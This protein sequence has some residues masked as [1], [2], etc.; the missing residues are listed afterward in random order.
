MFEN[1][2]GK[3]KYIP[4]VP[5]SSAD[6]T[7]VNNKKSCPV[8]AR[9]NS[10]H[11]FPSREKVCPNCKYHFPMNAWERIDLL[12]DPESFQEMDENLASINILGFPGYE[13]KLSE[14][15]KKSNLNE[16]IIC[17]QAEL[18]GYPL[19]LAVMDSNFMMGSMGSVVGEKVC[20]AAEKAIELNCPLIICTASGGARMQEGMISLMQMAKTSAVL[21]RFHQAGLLYI[22]I[23]TNPTTG[24]VIASFASLADI[25]IAEP[26]ALV[27]FTGPRVITQTMGQK[28]PPGFQCSEFLLEHGQVDLI[29]ERG[30]LKQKLECLLKLY[31][32]GSHA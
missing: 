32:G 8:C 15:G 5:G 10:G 14:A 12:V 23:L 24:G 22:S 6:S 7:I 29:V 25:I 26:G 17:G 3:K 19:I 30:E 31:Q 13:E 20:R 21:K 16:A 1:V 11:E 18:G 28:L 4:L 2:L 27:G 9:L